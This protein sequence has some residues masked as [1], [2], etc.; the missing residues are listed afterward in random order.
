M[1][2]SLAQNIRFQ[3]NKELMPLKLPKINLPNT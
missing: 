2:A 1:N 3:M